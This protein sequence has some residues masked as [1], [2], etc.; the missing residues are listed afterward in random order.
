MNYIVHVFGVTQRRVIAV[1]GLSALGIVSEASMGDTAPKWSPHI[2][3][4]ANL[5]ND[6][7][8]NQVDFF[9]PLFQSNKT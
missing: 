1:C 5:T 6:R 3:F 4:G 2:D 7:Q 9:L 8:V